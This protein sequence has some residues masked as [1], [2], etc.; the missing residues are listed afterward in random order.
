V[1][2]GLRIGEIVHCHEFDIAAVHARADD[3]PADTPESINAD[4]DCHS[5]LL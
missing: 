2:E 3:V 1:R 4:F 5:I